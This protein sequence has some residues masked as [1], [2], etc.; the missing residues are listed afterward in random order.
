[1]SGCSKIRKSPHA[2]DTFCLGNMEWPPVSTK[3][4][5]KVNS[6]G[7]FSGDLGLSRFAVPLLPEPHLPD[8]SQGWCHLILKVTTLPS[9]AG[10][11]P[12]SPGKPPPEAVFGV[13]LFPKSQPQ[14]SDVPLL[15]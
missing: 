10:F 6:S 2:K 3:N 8:N 11:H 4:R 13:P 5:P 7:L 15:R 9:P 1:M 12:L 14:F